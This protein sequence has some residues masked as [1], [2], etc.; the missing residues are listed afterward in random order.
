MS[1]FLGAILA[2]GKGTR[3]APFSERYPKPLLP[4]GNK[5]LLEHQIDLMRGLGITEVLLLIGHKGYEIARALGDGDRMGVRIRYVEQTQTL[6][7]AHAV[8]RLEPHVD[9]RHCGQNSA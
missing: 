9:A 1:E 5:P 2:G 6:G 4:V 8:G 3:M 7:I